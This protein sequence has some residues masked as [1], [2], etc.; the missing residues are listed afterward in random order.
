M[1]VAR[2]G[3]VAGGSDPG[4]AFLRATAALPRVIL[5]F[6]L[7][8]LAAPALRAGTF[9]TAAWTDDA[10]SGIASGQTTWAY[11]F[12]STTA[13]TV[14][15][16]TVTGIAAAPVTTNPNF[17]LAAPTPAVFNN[18]MNTL[19]SLTGT[20]SAD[21][22]RDF[23]YSN[24]SGGVMSVT[25]KGLT[26]GGTYTVT[27]LSV[28]WE[29]AGA[30][31][32]T[33]ASGADS[34]SVDQGQFGDNY[35]IRIDYTFTATAATR[36]ITLTPQNASFRFHLY[37]LALRAEAAPT[38]VT[39]AADSG[40]GS[41]RWALVNAAERSGADTVTFASALS[42][43][44]IT[45]GS[46]IVINDSAGVTVDAS[47]LPGGIIVS[48][49]NAKRLLS[50]SSGSVVTLR[51]L[52]LTGGTGVGT[53]DSGRGGAVYVNLAT[54][55][56]DRCTLRDN[57]GPT[58]AV[59]GGG[60]YN[61]SS[62]VTLTGCTLSGNTT[63]VRGGALHNNFGTVSLTNCTLSGNTTSTHGGG[64]FN[65]GG[66]LTLTHCTVAGNSAT[67]AASGEGGG[68]FN[69]FA[70]NCTLENSI[71]ATNT[72]GSGFGEQIL[73]DGGTLTRLGAN[74]VSS[75]VA[76]TDLFNG[77]TLTG[78]GT[79]SNAAP[80]LAAL[81]SNG[82]PTQ[83]MLPNAGSPA[84]NA[85]TGSTA[86]TDQRGLSRPQGGTADIGAVEVATAS[87][88]VVQNNADAGPG[89]LR[90][91]IAD[92]ALSP[93]AD[94]ITFASGLSGQIITLGSEIVIADTAALTVDASSLPGGLSLTDTGNVDHRLLSTSTATHLT[95]CGLTLAGGGG[96][97]GDGGGSIYNQGNLTLTN[98][99]ISGSTA[100]GYGGAIF[101]SNPT[102]TAVLSLTG[103]TLANNSGLA[104]GAIFN[105]SSLALTNCTLSG[106]SVSDEGGGIFNSGSGTLT[107]TQS[108]LSGNSARLGGGIYSFGGTVTLTRS[109]VAGN[110]A[111]TDANISGFGDIFGTNNLTDG[112]PLLA[113]L[114]NYGGPTQTMPPLPGSPVLDAGGTDSSPFTTDQRGAPRVADGDGN[115]SALVDIGAVEVTPAIVSSLA[116][117]GA[118]SL[119][120][121]L[122]DPFTGIVF[123]AP[124]LSGQTITLTTGQL[125]LSRSV[126]IDASGVTGG[127]T[128]SGNSNGDNVLDPGES[129]LFD[130][131]AGVTVVLRKLNLV[132]GIANPAD[133]SVN[134]RGGAIHSSGQLTVDQC[135]ISACRATWGGGIAN[136]GTLTLTHSTLSGNA[137]TNGGGGIAN[138]GTLTLTHST[139]SGNAA[140]IGGGIYNEDANVT[141]GNSI[142]AGNTAPN[143]GDIYNNRLV[144][145]PTFNR[146]GANI[147]LLITNSGIVNESG[148]PV[149]TAAPLLRPLG[150][151][152]G[153]TPTM[154]PNADSPAIDAAVDS[155]AA[156]DQRG[157]ARPQGGTADIGAVEVA[158]ASTFVVQNIADSG[159][160]SLRQTLADAALFSPDASNTITF[161]HGL[162]GET[163]LLTTGHLTLGH[164]LTIDATGLSGGITI[165]GNSDGDSEVEAGESRIFD[166]PAGVTVTLLR[167]NLVNGMADSDDVPF[168]GRGGAIRNSGQLTVDRCT[169]SA[170]RALS[171][172]AIYNRT[173]GTL[174][175]IQS[176]LSG[177]SANSGG[178]LYNIGTA[179]LTRSTLSDN[180]AT[181][182]G[183]GIYNY[184]MLSLTQC[185]LSR[186]SAHSGGGI[187]TDGSVPLTDCTIAGNSASSQGGGIRTTFGS[188]TLTRTIIAANTAPNSANIFGPFSATH[189]L[190]S[191][192][193]LLAPLGNYGGP[194]QTMPP[195]PGSPAIDAGGSTTE[196]T[197]Q[198]G[199]PRVV[200]GNGDSTAS[201]DIGAVEV[202]PAIVTSTADSGPSSLR[203]VL[204]DPDPFIT[205]VIF[206]APLSGGTITL[207]SGQLTLSRSVAIDASH[208]AQGITLS[209]NSNGNATLDPGES[210]LFDIP[211]GVTVVLRRLN[212]INGIANP[213]DLTVNGAGGAIRSSGQLTLDQC[214]ISACRASAGGGLAT[215]GGSATVTQS[216]FSNNF[217]V[218]GGGLAFFDSTATLA[219]STVSSNS[220]TRGGGIFGGSLSYPFVNG[221]ITLAQCTLAGNSAQYGGGI[222][223]ESGHFTGN[224]VQSTISGNSASLFGSGIYAT[225]SG[226]A[227]TRCIVAGNAS[228]SS[229][230]SSMVP[231]GANNLTNG[232]PLLAPLGN[233]GGP[234]PTMPPLP[235]SP[236]LDAAAGSTETTDQ[237][238]APRVADGDGNGTAEVDIGA[239]EAIP[240]LVTNANDSGPGSLRAALAASSTDIVLFDPPLSGQTITL[241][242][243]QLTPSRSVGIDA[244]RLAGGL[245]ISG[246]S[247]G[248]NVLEP[249][250]S[251]LFDIPAGMALALRGLNLI[252]GIADPAMNNATGAGGA[253]RNSGQLTLDLCAISACRARFGGAIN[254]SGVLTARRSTFQQNTATFGGAI[255]SADN[256]LLT[257]AESTFLMNTAHDRGGAVLQND[258][259]SPPGHP[260]FTRCT[261]HGNAAVRG[262]AVNSFSLTNLTHCTLSGNSASGL[263]GGGVLASATSVVNLTNCVV[264]GNNGASPDL[265]IE[266]TGTYTTAGVNLVGDLT[267][268]GLSAGPTLLTG[269]PRLA[270]IA[271]YGGP[272]PTR[273]L[274]PT[275]PA[276]NATTFFVDYSDQRGFP[277]VGVR[278]LGAYEAGTL[279]D[280]NAFA[281]E[282]PGAA[283]SPTGDADNDGRSDLLEYATQNDP[284]ASSTGEITP[285]TTSQNA[286]GAVTQANVT[287]PTRVGATDLIYTLQRSTTLGAW[288]TVATWNATTGVLTQASGVTASRNPATGVVSVT[289][290]NV[291]GEDSAF[292][293]LD[294]QQV[295]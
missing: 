190:T 236:A 235:G 134:G 5:A 178:G 259:D 212:L 274:L 245:T 258:A 154:L 294:V 219:R 285:T 180:S 4:R 171:G 121:A 156:T 175:V 16:V 239:V 139:L 50:L 141:L 130:I 157:L 67:D 182:S 106:N 146:V 53:F 100:G 9:S 64:I 52:T 49:G 84:I 21:I 267:G 218:V 46:E 230:I 198:R 200:D 242:S 119:R 24:A 117:S 137:A 99:T 231:H 94:T 143:G 160:G 77:A 270:P 122:A 31:L 142:V 98:C 57:T 260:T 293:R 56:L 102:Q 30:R 37:G 40:P 15:G 45:L 269:D 234:T 114:G 2:G 74:L 281:I 20:G 124:G 189:T 282:T 79:V 104:G 196:T 169:V 92:A 287:F 207:T 289:D 86:A 283:L 111:A 11:H 132:N 290:T 6:L 14:N 167:L 123:F 150:N 120:A 222:S 131:P 246:G 112:D 203:E 264:A 254:S 109:I 127:I 186:N 125:T 28:G 278:D 1:A 243:G 95:L 59:D 60:I 158:T 140:S 23:V 183:G 80:N 73:Q 144:N 268:S 263:G 136:L 249:G 292:Y 72:A 228:T 220:A 191:G 251:R 179:T 65:K 262:G 177:N 271:D 208:L 257:V 88:F 214:A 48:G 255:H 286:A 221:T 295:P 29:A 151:Y 201:V 82:G 113:P 105:D 164:D 247:N 66:T 202:T 192:D 185:T 81:A 78:S 223:L 195:L 10:T 39:T 250:E 19:T 229:N 22:A 291:F 238:G 129:R 3:V 145:D 161:H 233:Y 244:T 149:I 165:S 128:I 36:L 47:G 27:F 83:T 209:G 58:P 8:A 226:V 68:I 205:T 284:H 273:A 43:Q 118:G 32:L 103:C 199:A 89:S 33:F 133:T 116:D 62:T 277:I 261:F 280:F 163:I 42:G 215:A 71:V 90:Q 224:L 101:N 35:G 147:V 240:A 288:T 93:G 162:S 252:N 197:D 135:A 174:S 194:T 126:A 115:G 76:G 41:L 38:T 51:R 232:D 275:S 34:R 168:N 110:T 248:D 148:P 25:V 12:G 75:L 70:I 13:S 7:L 276:R 166:V 237:R 152:G 61:S 153:P 241:T 87:T 63:S 253:I 265:G 17:D 206:A 184:T 256:G 217:A 159:P 97:F 188:A 176:T 211:A 54:L 138:A 225:H 272:T 107:L 55:T 26:A 279:S 170:C 44:T 210:R 155:T 85:A 172:A 204:A 18:D 266:G 227:L 187:D 96:A 216:T 213:A 91:I 69:D 173:G 181:Q 108:T 193:P